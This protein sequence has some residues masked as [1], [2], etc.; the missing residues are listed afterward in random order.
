[1]ARVKAALPK[2]VMGKVLARNC[3]ATYVV[4][5]ESSDDL[6]LLKMLVGFSDEEYRGYGDW[7]N[8]KQHSA[9]TNRIPSGVK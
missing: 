2:L 6:V 9:A 5:V 8:V 4:M 7:F 1:M 3:G